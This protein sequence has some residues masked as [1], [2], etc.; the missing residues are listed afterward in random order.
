MKPNKKTLGRV[1]AAM[2]GMD[3]LEIWPTYREWEND[4]AWLL[5]EAEALYGETKP[6][7]EE[8]ER[9]KR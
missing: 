4:M 9:S 7:L 2:I 5:A 8:R 1:V 6:I 3:P